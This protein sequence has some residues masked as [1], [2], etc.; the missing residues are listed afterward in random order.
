MPESQSQHCPNCHEPVKPNWTLCPQCGYQKPTSSGQIRCRV[1]GRSA[2]GILRTCPH[3]GAY[4]EPKSLP[5]FQ[6]VVGA[7][8]LVA[9]TV[10]FIQVG[11][12]ISNSVEQVA[13]A[14][15]PPT[16]TATNTA[17]TTPTATLTPMPTPSPTE[18]ATPTDTPTITLTP[19]EVP[20][21][22]AVP[23]DTPVGVP[24]AT[25]TFTPTPSATPRFGKP[26][27]L[28]PKDGKLFGHHEEVVLRWENMGPLGPDEWYA[29]RM[30]WQQDGQTAFGGHNL[31]DNFWVVPPDLYWGLADEFTGRTYEWFV[32]IE[33][34]TTDENGR[35]VGRPVSEVSDHSTFLWQE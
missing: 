12:F 31:K 19:T 6:I 24:T 21:P 16:P 35:Q 27:L 26:I 30:S 15:N 7:V 18:S 32:F 1:C 34:V 29:V 14:V 11:P 20:S 5:F 3:C 17:T 22:T 10:G 25:G 13:L 8:V 2:S 33:E 4:L 9:L 23:S 28:G